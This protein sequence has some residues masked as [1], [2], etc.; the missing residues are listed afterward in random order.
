MRIFFLSFFSMDFEFDI[1]SHITLHLLFC[2]F[3]E[4]SSIVILF[5][6]IYIQT[7]L[8]KIFDDHLMHI[9]SAF[10][11]LLVAFYSTNI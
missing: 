8:E 11:F 2:L 9:P 10:I 4:K 6:F 7:Y 3:C 1:K 5:Y